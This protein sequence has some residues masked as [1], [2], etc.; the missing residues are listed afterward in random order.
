MR[1]FPCLWHRPPVRPWRLAYDPPPEFE[2]Q[3]YL[4]D[5]RSPSASGAPSV[6]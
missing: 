2:R 6:R 4:R 3:L 1:L 5:L